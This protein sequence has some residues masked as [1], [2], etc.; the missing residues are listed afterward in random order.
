ML[1]PNETGLTIDLAFKQEADRQLSILNQNMPGLF[2]AEY[3]PSILTTRVVHLTWFVHSNQKGAKADGTFTVKVP[4]PCTY[5]NKHIAGKLLAT[6]T[7]AL[8]MHF[9]KEVGGLVMGKTT[10]QGEAQKGGLITPL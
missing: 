4:E 1:K 10:S 8:F 7:R 3:I 6:A 5:D 9:L 2:V